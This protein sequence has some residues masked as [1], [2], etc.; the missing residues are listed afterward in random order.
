MSRH[1]LV[2][3]L[4][5][6]LLASAVSPASAQWGYR[7]HYDPIYLGIRLGPVPYFTTR[8]GGRSFA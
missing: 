7:G 1:S 4:T 8:T 5:F 2:V 6:A 3:P